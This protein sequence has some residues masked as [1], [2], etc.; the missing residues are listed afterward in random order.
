M[1]PGVVECPPVPQTSPNPCERAESDLPRIFDNISQDLLTAL[2]QTLQ[3][4][5]RADY[6]VGYF[7]LRGWQRIDSRIEEWAGGPGAQCRVL[8]GMQRSDEEDLKR[9]LAADAED[10]MDN[11]EATR[12]RRRAAAAF[13]EQL[14]FGVPS[15]ADEAALRRLSAQLRAGKVFVRLHLRHTLHAKLYLHHRDDHA[16]PIVGFLGSSNLTLA[17]L[18]HQGELN[19]DVLDQDACQKLQRWFEDRWSDPFCVDVSAELADIIDQSWA[20]AAPVHPYLVYLK[21]AYHLSESGLAGESADAIPAEFNS[22][23]LKFQTPA[24][25]MAIRALRR[26][27][28]VLLGDVVGL[29]KTLMAT[30][31]ARA[32]EDSEG[33]STLIICPKNLE[34]MWQG[35]VRRHGMRAEVIPSSLIAGRLD[36]IPARYKLVVIDESHNFRNREGKTYQALRAWIQENAKYCL[37]LSATPYN[38]SYLDLGSQLGLFIDPEAS[39]NKRPEALISSLGGPPQFNARHSQIRIDTLGAFE[40]SPYTDDWRDLLQQYM[41]RRPR[42]LIQETYAETDDATGRRY[43]EFND[44]RRF[45]F[46]ARVPRT[47]PFRTDPSDADDLYARLYSDSVRDAIENLSLPR[48]GLGNYA[49]VGGPITPDSIEKKILDDLNRAGRRLI[50]FCRTNLFKRLESGGP[51]FLQSLERHILRNFIVIHAIDQQLPI[52]VGT[53][54]V[55][56][57]S[58]STTDADLDTDASDLSAGDGEDLP[59]GSEEDVIEAPEVAR[60]TS[61]AATTYEAYWRLHRSKYRWIRPGLFTPSL[62]EELLADAMALIGVLNTC[63]EWDPERDEKLNE[64]FNLLTM[65]HRAD[66]VVVFTQFA[67]TARYLEEQLSRRGL[68]SFACVTGGSSDPTAIAYRFSPVSNDVKP[69]PRPNEELRVLVATDVL[70]EGQNLQDAAIVVNFDLPWAI[71]RL[72]QRAGRVDRIGQQ[73]AEI[74]CYSFLPAEGVE[75]IIRLRQ[76][77]AARLHQNEEVVGSDERFFED[78]LRREPIL[79]IYSERAGVFDD[80]EDD[81]VDLTSLALAVWKTAIDADPALERKVLSLPDV[82]YATK[83]AGDVAPDGV[84]AYVRTP[85]GNDVMAWID[86]AGRI[87]SESK[88]TV[89]RAAA[90]G[91]STDV[92]DRRD[93]HHQLVASLARQVNRES[94]AVGG[95][96]GSKTSARYRVY[97]QLSA[98][99]EQFHRLFRNPDALARVIDDIYKYPL[100]PLAVELLNR[101]LKAGISAELLAETC[102][103]LREE[104]RFCQVPFEGEDSE[105]QSVR[106]LCS[107]GL[108]K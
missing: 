56:Y 31:V 68:D 82:V 106:I 105:F 34:R 103:R 63:G 83:P 71:I 104:G 52:P 84:L 87:V 2:Q 66:K 64:L 16:S 42:S 37:L 92:L 54:D 30:A 72:I 86:S 74:L 51:A 19:V 57:M 102:I 94:D 101:E 75:Q 43:L 99:Y 24:V 12:L 45:F 46:P 27:G 91:P 50:G 7:N 77:V 59:P 47:V 17:G 39:M 95:Q 78:Q 98:F 5:T 67:D 107:L 41:V 32:F 70:S 96:L 3:G 8:I 6:C 1:S 85:R 69:R 76:R 23:L 40:L 22:L 60:F 4:S 13:K 9:A 49:R 38:K 80:K 100:R 58:E 28:G 81:E 90:C 29:G 35:Y 65:T 26:N 11:A 53:Q 62:R 25:L 88:P 44:G 55:A 18:L 79:D 97:Q 48:Y 61:L 21:M 20:A 14:T 89:F 15:N 93:D 10:F 108:A 36:G 73:A 33:V